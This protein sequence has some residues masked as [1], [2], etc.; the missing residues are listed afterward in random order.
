M[1]PT[2]RHLAGGLAVAVLGLFAAVGSSKDRPAAKATASHEPPAEPNV[3]ATYDYD[4]TTPPGEVWSKNNTS[5]TPVE[6][7]PFLGPFGSEAV[8]LTL[9]DLPEHKLVEIS[10]R[11]FVIRSWDGYHPQYGHDTWTVAIEDRATLLHTSFGHPDHA[12]GPQAYPGWHGEDH[13]PAATE[14]LLENKLGY[15]FRNKPCDAEYQLDLS[16]PHQGDSLKVAFSA[17]IEAV[18]LTD[19]SWGL[20]SVT[21]RLLDDFRPAEASQLERWIETVGK[22]DPVA[23]YEAYWRIAATGPAALE[24][25]REA[26][27]ELPPQRSVRELV[28]MFQSDDFKERQLATDLLL[29]RST[30]IADELDNIARDPDLTPEQKQR[31]NGIRQ[32]LKHSA[33]PNAKLLY[34]RRLNRLVELIEHGQKNEHEKASDAKA[35][36]QRAS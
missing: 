3:V 24:P 22:R 25:L 11:L 29:A 27:D 36:P 9:D 20:D 21:V 34:R 7:R 14:A 5:A 18:G 30:A 6:N 16:L 2:T 10:V 28:E 8:S 15:K 26:L 35:E 19:E 23:A 31:I 17:D 33:E 4:F 32:R 13:V 12:R 1:T